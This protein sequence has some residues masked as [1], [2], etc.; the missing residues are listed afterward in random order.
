MVIVLIL[1]VSLAP[2]IIGLLA[3]FGKKK[4]ESVADSS[5]IRDGIRYENL[6]VFGA[7]VRFSAP[8]RVMRNGCWLSTFWWTT[9]R[10][11][12]FGRWNHRT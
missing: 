4:P 7:G 1:L 12:Q 2:T 8:F 6:N 3:K 11:G 5:W 9:C 10:G